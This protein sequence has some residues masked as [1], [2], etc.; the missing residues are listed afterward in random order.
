MCKRSLKHRMKYHSKST[1]KNLM[2]L[3]ITDVILVIY[4]KHKQMCD[5]HCLCV[6]SSI[7]SAGY[8]R[9]HLQCRAITFFDMYILK[10]SMYN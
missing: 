9:F 1:Q 10:S 3:I 7:I 5:R 4:S 8:N 2:S 6:A